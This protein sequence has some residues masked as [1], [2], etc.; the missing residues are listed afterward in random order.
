M[1]RL[2]ALVTG[3]LAGAGAMYFFDPQYGRRRRALLNDQINRLSNEVADAFDVATRD[4]GNR[5]HGTMAEASSLLASDRPPDDVLVQRIRSKLGRWVSH[6]SA[7]EV[8]AADGQ[9]VLRGPVLMNE[10][11]SLVQ[12]VRWMHGVRHVDNQLEVHDRPGDVPGL[13]GEGRHAASECGMMQANWSPG[14]RL[15]AGAIG[16]LLMANCFARRSG[17]SMLCGTIGLGLFTRAM[18]GSRWL[19]DVDRFGS[20]QR[21]S[22]VTG[23]QSE[24]GE[25]STTDSRSWSRPSLAHEQEQGSEQQLSQATAGY[26]PSTTRL[27]EAAPFTGSRLPESDDIREPAPA[28]PAST[29]SQPSTGAGERTPPM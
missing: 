12:A 5:V 24:S 13:Q 26:G 16:G 6:P 29:N 27:S 20:G 21:T 15:A 22:G 9:V 17:S 14:I 25:S 2:N 3:A 28:W 18:A 1:G 4:L 7:I 8:D 10:V 23:S 19:R 11:Q